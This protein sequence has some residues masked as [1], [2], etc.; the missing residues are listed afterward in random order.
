MVS[1]DQGPLGVRAL[2]LLVACTLAAC[3]YPIPEARLT[4]KS[5]HFLE[6]T[7][8]RKAVHVHLDPLMRSLG[9][10]V[11]WDVREWESSSP[12]EEATSVKFS[13]STKAPADADSLFMTTVY[14]HI[15]H[16][17]QLTVVLHERG[18]RKMSLEGWLR[19][20]ALRNALEAH[21]LVD[22][23]AIDIHPAWHS[24]A[25]DRAFFSAAT[26]IPLPE[27]LQDG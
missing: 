7:L 11:E 4:V 14:T 9:Y 3:S 12:D 1:C 19:W 26:G 24:G 2:A 18:R 20:K 10:P 16:P 25:E 6:P 17:G 23:V 13:W 22:E 21:P 27:R 8:D 15:E 5:A